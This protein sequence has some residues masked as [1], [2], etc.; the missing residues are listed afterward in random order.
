MKKSFFV[1]FTLFS[2]CLMGQTLKTF[3]GPF[4]DGKNQNG[5]AVY[6]YFEDPNTREYL[7]QGEFKYTFIGEGEYKGYDQTITGTFDKGLKNGTWTYVINMT[8]F[9][10]DNPY[11]TGKVYLIAHYKNGYADGNWKEVCEYKSRKKYYQYG[12][13][14]WDSFGPTK[15][16]TISMNFN[17]G[18]LVGAVNINDEFL[19]FIAE[20]SYSDN[21]FA[22]GTWLIQNMGWGDRK[23]LIYTDNFLY[24]FV[25]RD[26]SGEVLDGS[27]KYQKSFDNF[28]KAKSLNAFER[29][30]LGIRIDSICG[31]S[32]AATNNIQDYFSKLLSN[33]YFLYEY[34][35]GDLTYKQGL[36]GGCEYQVKEMNYSQLSENENYKKA[37]EA[38]AKNDLIRALELYNYV[39]LNGIKPSER[40]IVNKKKIELKPKVD[41]LVNLYEMNSERFFK[42]IKS[43][44]DSIE[45]D[46]NILKQNFKMKP[47][48]VY[49]QNTYKYEEL[50]PRVVSY[51]CD[52]VNPWN[53]QNESL[54]LECFKINPKFY[55]PYQKLIMESFFEF[56][57]NLIDVENSIKRT[58]NFIYFDKKHHS[59]YTYDQQLFSNNLSKGKENYNKAKSLIA[60][61]NELETNV[62][63]MNSLYET[64]KK[65]V[66]YSKYSVVLLDFQTRYNSYPNISDCNEI[67]TEANK[68][69]AKAMLLYSMDTK[70][71]EKELK[72]LESVTEIKNLFLI[73]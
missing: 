49:N 12:Q 16:M 41:S 44:H 30:E 70:E 40:E 45:L 52:C 51:D 67:L 22:T 46:F 53:Q 14:S 17:N 61:V 43:E 33:D 23:E 59:F 69:V 38:L 7:K 32:C 72:N 21:G 60:L 28:N 36:L 9:G 55:E 25:A 15:S 31:S 71:F 1:L 47:I 3:N 54:S 63:K 68:F 62:N 5:T 27:M 6:N 50:K 58:S 20:G 65:K 29:E 42:I 66:L 13:Y 35:K 39:D 2:M 73:K 4:Q 34:I 56:K 26:N 64:D 11:Y 10:N 18:N 19:K 57:K 48:K 37:E 8:D 24:E